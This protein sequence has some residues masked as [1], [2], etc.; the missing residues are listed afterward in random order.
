V[1]NAAEARAI[2]DTL[3][4]YGAHF[5]KVYE[6]LSRDAYFA[7]I[8]EARKRGLPV[9]G[10]VPFRVRPE[11]AAAAGQRT[12]EHVLA[13]AAGCS[14]AADAERERFDRVLSPKRG[15]PALESLT[16]MTLFEHERA[17]YARRDPAACAATIES[18]KR[19]GVAE[20]PNIVA[21]RDVV[22]AEEILAD[23][24]IIRFVPPLILSN[25]RSMVA[26]DIYPQLK[27]VLEPMVPLY[28]ENARAL[29]E[30]GVVLLAATDVGLPALVPGLS[31]HEE[32]ELL[33]GA[34]LTPVAALQTATLNPARVLGFADSLGS[35]A[36]GK[37]ADLVILDANPLTDI[38]NSRR[39]RAVL[40]DGQPFTR[41]ELERHVVQNGLT[42]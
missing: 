13:M 23:T 1:R 22:H 16:P 14:T 31:L 18:Y 12:F 4:K 30:A 2:V 10:H 33:V 7:I 42:K 34:G 40:V 24:N 6:N 19:H 32:L 9:D 17:L 37:L 11:E 35:I 39:I 21:Y 38:R 28:A 36:L 25:W 5:I 15:A 8:D 29:Y 27:A 41:D 20:A 26:S 3:A